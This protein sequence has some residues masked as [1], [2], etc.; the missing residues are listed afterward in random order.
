MSEP[1]LALGGA[2][3]DG[4]VRVEEIGPQGMITIRGDITSGNLQ[5]PV[6]SV[7]GSAFPGQREACL[8]GDKGIL[9]MS[10]DEVMVLVPYAEAQALTAD[11]AAALSVDH[12]LVANV[13][14]ARACF[15]LTGEDVR[16]VIAKLAPVDMS[17]DA[18][19]PGQVRRTRFAQVAAAFWMV[20]EQTAQIVCF[21]SVA[22]YMFDL[23]SVA[24]A[25]GSKVGYL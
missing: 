6:T 15:R 1:V 12:S 8:N 23:L 16:E 17:R 9:W 3:Y 21:R 4:L 18:F 7:T 22:Q 10:P 2:S 13:S 11:L 14:D 20:D 5:K 25:P 24:A 19:G